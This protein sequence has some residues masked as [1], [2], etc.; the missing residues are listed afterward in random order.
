MSNK[1]KITKASGNFE[2]HYTY[3]ELNKRKMKSFEKKDY[4]SVIHYCYAMIEDRLLSFLHYLYII[5]R[6]IY[7]F[8]FEKSVEKSFTKL[9]YPNKEEETSSPNFKNLNTKI[10]IIKNLYNYKKDDPTILRVKRHMDSVLNMKDLKND[11]TKLS[12]WSKYRNEFTHSMY[13]KDIKSIDEH[14]VANAKEGLYLAD[15]FDMY[16]DLLKGNIYD[17]PSLRNKIET[18]NTKKHL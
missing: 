10:K 13:N 18:N 16:S 12:E 6:N 7:P 1:P 14:L 5:D 4:L 15:R 8:K 17:I 3:L 9:M 2:K 11:I